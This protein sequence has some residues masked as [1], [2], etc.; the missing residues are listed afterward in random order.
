MPPALRRLAPP[1]AEAE[2]ADPHAEARRAAHVRYPR[3]EL[4]GPPRGD[5]RGDEGDAAREDL[6]RRVERLGGDADVH[7]ALAAVVR[8]LA[9]HLGV[10]LPG[11]HDPPGH[12]DI[13]P[14]P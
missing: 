3:A 6:A 7:D 5:L 13:S 11:P 8:D 1:E 4:G 2:A 10:G 12:P 14:R 9:L